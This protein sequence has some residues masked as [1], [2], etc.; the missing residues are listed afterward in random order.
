VIVD[1]V[2]DISDG[3]RLDEA[4]IFGTEQQVSQVGVLGKLCVQ[5]RAHS[6]ELNARPRRRDVPLVQSV[7]RHRQ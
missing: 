7:S 6:V 5:H 2:Q 3:C 4:C 1:E